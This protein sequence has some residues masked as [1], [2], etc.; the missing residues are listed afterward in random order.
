MRKV[1]IY[2]L[3]VISLVSISSCSRDAADLV[4]RNGRVYTMEESMPWASAVVVTGNKI[5]AVLENDADAD[6]YIG[7][8]TN[9]IDLNGRFV[10]PGFIDGHTHFSG[11]GALI[12]GA[13]LLTVSDDNGLREEMTRVVGILEGGEWI[14]GGL[15]GA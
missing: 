14:S 11:A 8:G 15:W 13:N 2:V 9:E 5:T 10:M 7:E 4:L 12:N 1:A 3:S 6:A